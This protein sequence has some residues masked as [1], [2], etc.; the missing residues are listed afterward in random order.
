MAAPFQ[1]FAF[2][3]GQELS[4]HY[5]RLCLDWGPLDPGDSHS[6]KGLE[7]GNAESIQLFEQFF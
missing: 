6:P 1:S 2:D 3:Q 4:D 7:D 5:G